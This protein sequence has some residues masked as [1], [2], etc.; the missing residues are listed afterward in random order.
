[1]SNSKRANATDEDLDQVAISEQVASMRAIAASAYAID[2]FL[3][4]H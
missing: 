1:M 4:E 2:G 3:R